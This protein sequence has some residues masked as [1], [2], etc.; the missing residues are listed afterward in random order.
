MIVNTL[1]KL[2]AANSKMAGARKKAQPGKADSAAP[3]LV[4]HAKATIGTANLF[5]DQGGAHG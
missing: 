3:S 5:T 4:E 2:H 1:T